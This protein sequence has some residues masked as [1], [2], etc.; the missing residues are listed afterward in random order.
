MNKI[1]R[2]VEH[3][4]PEAVKEKI[5]ETVGFWRVQ[6][7]L[8]ILNGLVD[9][10][11]AADIALHTGLAVQTVHNLV[12][13]YNR[14]GPQVLDTPGKGGRRRSYLSQEEEREFLAPFLERALTGQ[15]ATAGE[16]KLALETRLKHGV[17][18]ST[19]YRILKRQ[20][21]RKIAPRPAHVESNRQQQE[22]F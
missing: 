21:W 14:L 19:V 3:L 10:R 8:V 13:A 5:K 15:I 20:G 7:W 18:K 6:K 16:I 17:D 2:V 11:S 22:E 9:P 4:S 12:A 1:T